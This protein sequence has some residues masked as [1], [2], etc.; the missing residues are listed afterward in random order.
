[1][2]SFNASM[3]EGFT[4]I[5]STWIETGEIEFD[6]INKIINSLQDRG[7]LSA[8]EYEAIVN[9]YQNVKNGVSGSIKT[10]LETIGTAALGSGVDFDVSEL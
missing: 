5:I 8:S 3:E 7:A 6:D 10:L 2:E 4:S 1:M 9:E